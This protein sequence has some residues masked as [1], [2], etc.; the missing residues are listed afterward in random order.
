MQDVT[1][2]RLFERINSLL[3][4]EERKGSVPGLKLVHARMLDYLAN[5]SSHSDTPMAVAGY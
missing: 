1:T 2:F 4:A 3:Q 5:C